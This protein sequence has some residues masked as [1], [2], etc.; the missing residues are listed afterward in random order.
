[1]RIL[2]EIVW[3]WCRDKKSCFLTS[4]KFITTRQKPYIQNQ[5]M[6]WD[7]LQKTLYKATKCGVA[8]RVLPPLPPLIIFKFAFSS[9]STRWYLKIRDSTKKKIGSTSAIEQKSWKLRPEWTLLSRSRCSLKKWSSDESKVPT[10]V[11]PRLF[12]DNFGAIKP[13]EFRRIFHAKWHQEE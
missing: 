12:I 9:N 10:L 5:K 2:K 7:H 6:S 11:V 13:I 8:D 1:M 4:N 3:N